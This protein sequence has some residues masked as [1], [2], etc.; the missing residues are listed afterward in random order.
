MRVQFPI[1]VRK[2]E[3]Q[4][5]TLGFTS[6]NPTMHL[7]NVVKNISDT[8]GPAFVTTHFHGKTTA[9]FGP[10]LN[11]LFTLGLLRPKTMEDI[12]ASDEFQETIKNIKRKDQTKGQEWDF[13]A[14]AKFHGLKVAEHVFKTGVQITY[15]EFPTAFPTITP[16]HNQYPKAAAQYTD[17]PI[18]HVQRITD[19]PHAA[20]LDSFDTIYHINQ[21]TRIFSTI[22][23]GDL[24]NAFQDQE[25]VR[26]QPGCWWIKPQNLCKAA[27]LEITAIETFDSSRIL[28]VLSLLHFHHNQIRRS[29]IC[30]NTSLQILWDLYMKVADFTRTYPP[31]VNES[32]TKKTRY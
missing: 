7:D 19:L 22:L 26:G 6:T 5:I 1:A 21:K 10:I 30:T 8:N 11:S 9:Q 18:I 14:I 28:Q 15:G 4:L 32:P 3:P 29:Q 17:I 20:F 12:F 2:L 16:G 25:Y 31:F 13:A 23:N 24:N 27:N